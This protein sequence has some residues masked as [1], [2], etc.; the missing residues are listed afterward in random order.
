MTDVQEIKTTC[1]KNW[2]A[3]ASENKKS[4]FEIYE[5]NGI[6]PVTCRHGL[7]ITFTEMVRSRE[8]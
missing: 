4:A 6:F 1:S 7:V 8:L 5:T 3:A 2:T